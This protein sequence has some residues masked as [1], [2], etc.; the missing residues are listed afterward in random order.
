MT[1]CNT[2]RRSPLF[3]TVGIISDSLIYWYLSTSKDMVQ[4]FSRLISFTHL[5]DMSQVYVFTDVS[6][7]LCLL[8]C[9]SLILF[10]KGLCSSRSF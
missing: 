2:L 4:S 7:L 3:I 8:P 6:L 5:Y 9:Y 1:L 10:W